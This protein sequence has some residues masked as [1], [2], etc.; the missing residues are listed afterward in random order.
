MIRERIESF[1][2]RVRSI[3]FRGEKPSTPENC[4]GFYDQSQ[5]FG[6]STFGTATERERIMKE[7]QGTG[8]N[9]VGVIPLEEAIRRSRRVD[10]P[11]SGIPFRG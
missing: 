3:S 4:I 8:A 11:N 1:L 5:A 10:Q 7:L 6:Y 9:I 2:S